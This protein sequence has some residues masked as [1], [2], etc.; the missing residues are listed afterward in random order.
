MDDDH[1]GALLR[2]ERRRVEGL[3]HDTMSA[4]RDDRSV[5]ADD[6]DMS[7]SAQPLSAEGV[8]NAIEVSLQ[9]RLAA[10][11]RAEQRLRDGTFGRST[12]SGLPIPDERLEADP[13]AELTVS[14]AQAERQV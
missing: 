6:G 11:D 14:E 4:G 7:D 10:I 13:A 1:A 5:E 2:A 8:D 3:L 9:E 12:R